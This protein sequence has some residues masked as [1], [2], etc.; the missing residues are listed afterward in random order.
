M[1][2]AE[3]AHKILNRRNTL[4]TVVLAGEM[5]ET[6]GA[7][8]YALALERRWIEPNYESGELSIATLDRTLS[9]MRT[10]ASQVKVEPVA[11]TAPTN[12]YRLFANNL[13]KVVVQQRDG[14]LVEADANVTQIG[15]EVIVAEDGKSYKA[16]VKG[17][18]PD[19]TFTL[20]FGTDKPRNSDA[21]KRPYKQDELRKTAGSPVAVNGGAS[22][23][24][25]Q[26][27]SSKAPF[28]GA[29]P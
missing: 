1:N 12:L 7:D 25:V 23:A 5:Q 27:P 2:E 16:V 9:E 24:P 15:D 18:N 13:P 21:E 14:S 6:L 22:P 3:I 28:A 26:A 8:G 11:E 17:R 29:A 10:L 19:G 20:S 4:S